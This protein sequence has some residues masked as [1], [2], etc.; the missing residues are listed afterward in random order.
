M[1]CSRRNADMAD[2]AGTGNAVKRLPSIEPIVAIC[3]R[4]S[5]NER[6]NARMGLDWSVVTATD[7]R[8]GQL[9]RQEAGR[10]EGRKA[11]ESVN[12]GWNAVMSVSAAGKMR[13][14]VAI[15]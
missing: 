5:G 1:I 8:R 12:D 9:G 6:A 14:S 4:H 11:T 2:M 3:H 15:I 7:G 10:K 13:A